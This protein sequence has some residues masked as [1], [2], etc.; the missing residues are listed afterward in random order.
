MA[1]IAARQRQ[2]YGNTAAWIANNIV[3]GAGEIGVEVVSSSDVRIKIGDGTST[4]SALPYASASST[5]INDA[6][7]TALDAKVPLAGGTMTGLLILSGDA[8]ADL[9]AVTKQQLDAV[10]TTLSTS[11]SGKLSTSGGTLTGFLTLNAAPTSS[12]HAATKSYVDTAAAAKVS[13][14]GDTMTGA[15]VLAA[16]PTAALEAAT[17]QYVD[18]GAYQTTVGGSATYAGKVVKTNAAGKID[19]SFLSLSGGYLGTVDVTVAY[20]L[21]GSF[22]TGDYYAI[23]VSGTV[24]S[25]WNDKINGSPTDAGAG[26]FLLR[27]SNGKWD[28]VGDTASSSAISGKVDKAGDTMTGPLILDADPTDALGAATKQ[29]ADLMLPLTG[30]T[31]TGALTLADDPTSA[32]EA[33]TKQYVDALET[34]L[35]SDFTDADDALST[36]LTTSINGKLSLSGGTLTGA[37]IL[38]ADPT[39]ALGAATKQY[40]DTVTAGAALTANN[41]SDLTDKATA[42]GNLALGSLAQLSTVG[43]AQLA[44]SAV[45]YAKIQNVSASSRILGRKTSGAG[46]IEELTLSEIL[47]FIGSA[48][49]G[50]I[51]YRGASGWAR[52]PA[53]TSGQFLKT[54]GSGA[55]PAWATPASGGVTQLTVWNPA[56]AANNTF[57][58]I[59]ST[60]KVIYIAF[61][62]VDVSGDPTIKLGTSG[63]LISSAY[64]SVSSRIGGSVNTTTKNTGFHINLN[65]SVTELS[66]TIVLTSLGGNVWNCSYTLGSFDG[67][68]FIGSGSITLSGTLDRV[69]VGRLTSGGYDG[70]KVMVSYV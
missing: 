12:L 44:N 63:G 70:G 37:L 8:V 46:T 30:G 40:V 21:S 31:L 19:S 20:A 24:D 50:D 56:G 4:F 60:A 7:Q 54:N 15:L 45:T 53:G 17:K 43:T 58:G 64:T 66:G 61:A 25:S 68:S 27:N 28:L 48:A 9:G 55:D 2:I 5:T 49:R 18:G 67:T 59:P 3:L 62:G 11:I 32:L 69:D 47:D 16:D 14:S 52:L 35:T 57:T 29:Y 42:R 36:T 34:S 13:K 51:L 6:T 39:T 38:A 33:A 26:Q 41:L 1:D 22:T 23:S 65:T 10:N